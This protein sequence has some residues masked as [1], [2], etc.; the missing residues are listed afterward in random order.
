MSNRTDIT[1]AMIDA[2]IHMVP[3]G[4]MN[5]HQ[6]MRMLAAAL[7]NQANSG[8]A[9]IY[10]LWVSAPLG[11]KRAR[12]LGATDRRCYYRVE[13]EKGQALVVHGNDIQANRGN[14]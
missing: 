2:A 4:A 9:A 8:P 10:P 1:A 7:A 11:I 3:A 5:R 13:T 12:F 6:V 14:R